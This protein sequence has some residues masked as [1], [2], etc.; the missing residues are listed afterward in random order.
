[1]PRG[2]DAERL[3]WAFEDSGK[4]K[5]LAPAAAVSPADPVTRKSRRLSRFRINCFPVDLLV[6]R[7]GRDDFGH[8]LHALIERVY[9]YALVV[10]VDTGGLCRGPD[11]WDEAVAR[12]ADVTEK[13]TVCK[14]S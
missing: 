7:E 10:T 11:T 3:P 8:D 14:S 12:D 4:E 9:S 13:V 1:M 6:R 5:R 2:T